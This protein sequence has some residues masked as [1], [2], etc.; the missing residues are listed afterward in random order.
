M[1]RFLLARICYGARE[2]EKVNEREKRDGITE[3]QRATTNCVAHNCIVFCVVPA[4]CEMA[5]DA[6]LLQLSVVWLD[7]ENL[8]ESSNAIID[9]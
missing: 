7:R 9:Q 5:R 8:D 3:T 4:D 6:N 1:A 2:R